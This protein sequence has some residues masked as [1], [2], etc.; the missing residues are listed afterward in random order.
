MGCPA[1]GS[2]CGQSRAPATWP[3]FI[4]LLVKQCRPDLQVYGLA[5]LRQPLR[6][7]ESA[8]NVAG[9]HHI[10]SQ[11]MQATAQGLWVGR[12]AAAPSGRPGRRQRGRR[13]SWAARVVSRY[14]GRPK[15]EKRIRSLCL[16]LHAGANMREMAASRRTPEALPGWGL[17][18]AAA[19]KTLVKNLF[20]PGWPPGSRLPGPGGAKTREIDTFPL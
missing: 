14:M 15:L 20:E 17:K 16:P 13:S 2:P 1:C 4:I 3:A 6:A 12:P 5:G 19:V 11:T 10:V 18:V 9:V 8:G 7:E